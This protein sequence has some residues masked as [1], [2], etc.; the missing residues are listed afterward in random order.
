MSEQVVDFEPLKGFEDDYEILNDY[1]FTIRRKSNHYVVKDSFQK[2]SGY[3]INSLNGKPYR[4][5]RLIAL[6]FLY[7]DDPINKDI[8]DHINHDKTDN[9]LSNLR[10]C[11]YSENCFNRSIANRIQYEFIDDIPNDAIIV[12]FYDTRTERRE[13]E[14]E[15][16]YYYYDEETNEDIFYIR[17]ENNIYRKLYINIDKLGNRHVRMK[18]I[19]NKGV[20]LYIHRFKQQ[21]DLI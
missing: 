12:D 1:P 17:I 2:S 7:N 13:F 14:E 19:N 21:H 10:W 4:K 3:I 16:Y 20:G 11:S 6:Q 5:H 15:K 9:H 18:D 8:I